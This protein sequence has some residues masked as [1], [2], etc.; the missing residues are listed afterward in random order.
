MVK[1]HLQAQYQSYTCQGWF[2]YQ[3]MRVATKKQ[4]FCLFIK[5][6]YFGIKY[7]NLESILDCSSLSF[8]I[9]TG[10]PYSTKHKLFELQITMGQ[11]KS[12]FENNSAHHV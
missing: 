12:L 4:K 9:P 3:F 5:C 6:L 7:S 1:A 11:N 10:P 2:S 8:L